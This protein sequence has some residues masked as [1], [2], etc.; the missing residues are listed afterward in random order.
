MTKRLNLITGKGGV[1]KTTYATS[2]AVSLKNQGHRVLLVDLLTSSIDEPTIAESTNSIIASELGISHVS[3]KLHDACLEYMGKKLKSETIANWIIKTSFFRALI[4][5]IPGMNYLIYMGKVLSLLDQDPDLYIVLDAPASGH[6][7]TM[8]E[9]TKNFSEIFE[10][11]S[12]FEDTKLMLKYLTDKNF[13][14]ITVLSL[15]TQMALNEAKDLKQSV[16]DINNFSLEI[17][18]N[19]IISIREDFAKENLPE[20]MLTKIENEQNVLNEFKELTSKY[21]PHSLCV[22][23]LEII[24]EIIPSVEKLL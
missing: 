8:L 24:K 7:L 5:M 21:I 18:V 4:N 14:H 13:F 11:G 22:E 17:I 3:L 19:N 20:F 2:L 15:P 6:A 1:G 23:N 10:S 16:K 9:A 12:L